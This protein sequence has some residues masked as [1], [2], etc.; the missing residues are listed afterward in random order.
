M[1]APMFVEAQ[2]DRGRTDSEKPTMGSWTL[3]AISPLISTCLSA[4]RTSRL[5]NTILVI[6]LS[7]EMRFGR[8]I[9]VA[10]TREPAGIASQQQ[11]T[12]VALLAGYTDPSGC[13][14][15]PM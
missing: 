4:P 1:D 5:W 12:P 2:A 15:N 3:P 13:I 6:P 7:A 10:F 8:D 11:G 14:Q 9:A